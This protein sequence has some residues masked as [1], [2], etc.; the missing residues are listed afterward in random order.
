MTNEAEFHDQWAL[1]TAPGDVDVMGS[2][3]E[4]AGPECH[5]ISSQLGVIEGKR[6][7]EI[8]TGLGE[9]A[10]YLSM[11]G[12]E[13]IATDVSEQ[14]L[15]IAKQVAELHH[16][17]LETRIQISERLSEINDLSIDVVYAANVLHHSEINRVMEEVNRVLKPGGIFA[18]WDPLSYNPL[19]NAYRIMARSLHTDGE[20]PLNRK[21][22]R[23]ISSN[24]ES[25]E[26]RHFWLTAN[27]LFL[28][29]F[30]VDRLSP[31]KHRYWKLVVERRES[32][33]TLLQ[34]AHR[35]DRRLLSLFPPLKWLCW[36]VAIVARKK[37]Q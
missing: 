35:L 8:G 25:V 28:K 18:S 30:F 22:I 9:G 11:K 15:D 1:E 31:A 29:F 17:K 10:V 33:R 6:I 36:N 27:A 3:Q 20:K 2:W 12:A 23:Q 14:M 7:L 5:W 19:I 16:V 32:N 24:F 34:V 4:F 13:V 26:I 37:S 21:A